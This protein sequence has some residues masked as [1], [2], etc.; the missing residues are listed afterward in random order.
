MQST[1]GRRSGIAGR[2]RSVARAFRG[3]T[4]DEFTDLEAEMI[5]LPTIDAALQLRFPD[6]RHPT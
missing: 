1:I 6:C 3:G 5:E 4:D 2:V